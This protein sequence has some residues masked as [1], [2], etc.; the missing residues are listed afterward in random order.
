V[1]CTAAEMRRYAQ[2]VQH[3]KDVVNGAIS[4]L[5]RKYNKKILKGGEFKNGKRNGRGESTDVKGGE[6]SNQYH[7]YT[8][9]SVRFVSIDVCQLHYCRDKRARTSD[10]SL[11]SGNTSE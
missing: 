4:S 10:D 1:D 7:I 6:V 2:N 3:S 8:I 11:C 5:P 9:P